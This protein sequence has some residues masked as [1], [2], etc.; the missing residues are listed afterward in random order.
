MLE[1]LTSIFASNWSA[2]VTLVMVLCAVVVLVVVWSRREALNRYFQHLYG[3]CNSGNLPI[4]EKSNA[5]LRVVYRI[6]G[7]EILYDNLLRSSTSWTRDP[8]DHSNPNVTIQLGDVVHNE[9]EWLTWGPY[10]TIWK[11]Q[12]DPACFGRNIH[13]I[14]PGQAYVEVNH[15]MGDESDGIWFTVNPGSGMFFRLPD[16]PKILVTRNK[17]SALLN[18]LDGDDHAARVIQKYPNFEWN[19][20]GYS[21]TYDSE[22]DYIRETF[23]VHTLKE[24]LE[25]ATDNHD[26]KM[27]GL[28]WVADCPMV[29]NWVTELAIRKGYDMIQYYN[30]AY[31]GYWSNEFAWIGQPQSVGELI[32]QRISTTYGPCENLSSVALSCQFCGGVP[33]R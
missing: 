31:N 25:I 1:R 23:G 29:D 30:A 6:P 32:K 12:F 14:T 4:P 22:K 16:H 21:T 27:M 8:L 33:D 2:T 9:S 7:C 15:K 3:S 24:V 18:L 11:N 17:L 28:E 19:G 13:G 20:W 5:Q 10:P 26:Q